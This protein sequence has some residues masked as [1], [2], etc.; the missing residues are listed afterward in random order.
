MV[1]VMHINHKW[2]IIIFQIHNHNYSILNVINLDTIIKGIK[3]LN[4]TMASTK[5]HFRL[6]K[7]AP[8]TTPIA[9]TITMGFIAIANLQPYMHE[10]N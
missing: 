6:S 4:N 8:L 2:H 3:S 10:W 7:V 9:R 5:I 1:N